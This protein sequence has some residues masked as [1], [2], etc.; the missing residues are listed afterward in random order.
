MKASWGQHYIVF[1]SNSGVI[2]SEVRVPGVF[3]SESSPEAQYTASGWVVIFGADYS[4][5]LEWGSQ[6]VSVRIPILIPR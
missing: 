4:E 2:L 1:L 6:E 5:N 3:S